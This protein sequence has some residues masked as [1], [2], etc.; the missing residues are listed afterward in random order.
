MLK[1]RAYIHFTDHAD[2]QEILA[3]QVLFASLSE[4]HRVSAV[5]VGGDYI[6]Q[7]QRPAEGRPQNRNWAVLFTSMSAPTHSTP[8]E[9][10][11]E[12]SEPLPLL[13]IQVL[14]LHE[15]LNLLRTGKNLSDPAIRSEADLSLPGIHDSDIE[16]DL[17]EN[18]P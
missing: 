11:W 18:S 7:S 14:T 8:D 2:A 6:P 9:V 10:I 13:M 16:R 12:Q 5:E 15:A 3:S 17:I 4:P 1:R